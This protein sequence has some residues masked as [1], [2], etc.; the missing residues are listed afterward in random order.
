VLFVVVVV[1]ERWTGEERGCN[2]YSAVSNFTDLLNVG[3]EKES[4]FNVYST[5]ISCIG[6]LCVGLM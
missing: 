4:D 6:L 2:I 1:F 3:L 5:V